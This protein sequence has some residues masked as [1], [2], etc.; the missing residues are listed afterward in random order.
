M[1]SSTLLQQAHEGNSYSSRFELALIGL[2]TVSA[3]T[4][5]Y[6]AQKQEAMYDYQAAQVEEDAKQSKQA[7]QIEADKVVS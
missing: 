2:S 7:A 3:G 5:I 1:M 4:A 6:S